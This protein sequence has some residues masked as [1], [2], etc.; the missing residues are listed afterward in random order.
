MRFF[1]VPKNCNDKRHNIVEA[2]DVHYEHFHVKTGW[3]P[4]KEDSFW[5]ELKW[6]FRIAALLKDNFKCTICETPITDMEG[7]PDFSKYNRDE[8]Y[9]MFNIRVTCGK[10]RFSQS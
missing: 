10:H 8:I 3:S 5:K 7:G 9:H 1:R 4:D 2:S 6:D